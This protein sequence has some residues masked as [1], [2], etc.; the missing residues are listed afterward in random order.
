MNPKTQADFEAI[1]SKISYPKQAFIGGKF[2]NA[3]SGKTLNTINP[4]NGKVFAEFS[5][6][7]LEDIN[8]AVAIAR[9]TFDSGVWSKMHPTERKKVLLKFADAIETNIIELSVLETLDSGKP[10]GEIISTDIP[11]AI[12]A[13]RWH[14]EMTDKRYGQVSPSGDNAVGMITKEAVGVVACI[15]PW[16]FPIMTTTWK[17]A[18]ALAEGNSVILKPA[19]QTALTTL[20]LAEIAAEVGFPEGVIQV[21]PGAGSVLGEALG[22]HMGVNA[23]SF[24]G[25]TEVGRKLLAYS[26]QSN[27]KKIILELGGKSPFILLDDVKDLTAAVNA[28]LAASFWNTGQNCTANTRIFVPEVRKEEFLSMMLDGLKKD[29]HMGEPLNPKN[30]LGPMVSE[31]HFKSV[32]GY[33]EE[34]IKEGCRLATGGNSLTYGESSLYVAP[35][36]F[37]DPNPESVLIKQEIFGPI[38]CIIG[39]KSNEEAIAMA[40]DCEYGLQ[41]SLFTND[42]VKAHTYAR[43]IKAGTVSINRYCEGDISTPFGGLKM[44][45][46]GGQD[47]AEAAHDQY[48]EIKTIFIGLD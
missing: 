30:N 38:S 36:L 40:N 28:A 19:S 27:L 20:R 39:V 5:S 7:G 23:V 10:I 13:I 35:T 11:E 24:T 3:K 4:A 21:L 18:P 17:L 44:S 33:M 22:M 2:V 45:G 48:S 37:V 43:M 15:M 31:S 26:A 34:G 41:A 9:K 16:N 14:A 12:H 29:W 6:C 42:L 46:F 32:M 8:E 25:S 47:N 1:A